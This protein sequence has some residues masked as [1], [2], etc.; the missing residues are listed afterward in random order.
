MLSKWTGEVVGTAH[1]YGITMGELAKEVG[2]SREL[3]S[4]YLNEKRQSLSAEHRIRKAL[5]AIIERKEPINES[6][7]IS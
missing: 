7:D 4:M 5:I 6:E 2:I 1:I 3:L